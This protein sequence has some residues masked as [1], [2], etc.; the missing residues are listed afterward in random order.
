MA[1]AAV[2]AA[3]AFRLQWRTG[4]VVQEAARPFRKGTIRAVLG[5]GNNAIITVNLFGHPPQNFRPAQLRLL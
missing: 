4:R 3:V 5:T 2:N 1:K